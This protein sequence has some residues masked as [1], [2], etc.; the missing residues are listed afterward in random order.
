M[1]IRKI[2]IK[3]LEYPE[4]LKS[5]KNAPAS[6][7]LRGNLFPG[8]YCFAIVGSRLCSE[9]GKQ[10]SFE[11]AGTLAEKGLTIVSGLAEGIDTACHRAAIEKHGKT[12]AVL[13]TGLDNESIYPQSNLRLAEKI[14]ENNGCLISEYPPGTRGSKF[15]FPKRNRIISGLSIGILIVEAKEKSGTLITANFAK[16]QKKK[17]FAIPGSEGSDLLIKKGDAKAVNDINDILKE[18]NMLT[19]LQN[20]LN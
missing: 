6:L 5:I 2:S 13:G 3:D 15:T 8:D 17:I 14:I 20:K 11:I 1:E 16:L 18:L 19:K 10:K 12:I 9:R 7:Y 4:L